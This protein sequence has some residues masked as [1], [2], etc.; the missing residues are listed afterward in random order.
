MNGQF[1]DLQG[2]IETIKKIIDAEIDVDFFKN[3]AL[4]I[5]DASVKIINDIE[6]RVEYLE[7]MNDCHHGR[8][9]D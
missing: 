7:M 5:I 2:N 9:D 8:V 6:K 3:T 4:K 1:R